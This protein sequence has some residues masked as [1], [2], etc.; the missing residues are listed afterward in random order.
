[1]PYTGDSSQLSSAFRTIPEVFFFGITAI[2]TG[3]PVTLNIS[4]T[5]NSCQ[6]LGQYLYIFPS[7]NLSTDLRI[8]LIGRVATGGTDVKVFVPFKNRDK[9]Q[10]KAGPCHPYLVATIAATLI[11][12]YHLIIIQLFFARR[13][14]HHKKH[15]NSPFLMNYI[16]GAKIRNIFPIIRSIS[17]CFP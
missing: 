5:P 17:F 9:K 12:N 6:M 15:E 8:Q 10:Q 2:L 16:S 3:S 1:M 11:A 13:D 14:A 7:G 4:S